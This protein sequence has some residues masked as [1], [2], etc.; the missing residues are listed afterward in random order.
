MKKLLTLIMAIVCLA[1]CTSNDNSGNDIELRFKEG[2]FKIA[3]FTDIHWDPS[4]TRSESVPDS[5]LAV[6]EKERPDLVVMTGEIGRA[7]V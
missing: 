5:L 1:S 3:Q 7:H 2:K 6:L 4:N